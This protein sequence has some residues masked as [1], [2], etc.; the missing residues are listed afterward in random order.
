MSSIRFLLL[1]VR[2]IVECVYPDEYAKREGAT[3]GYNMVA[4][5]VYPVEVIGG[6]NFLNA[7]EDDTGSEK[8]FNNYVEI[9]KLEPALSA[10]LNPE[11][12]VPK[13]MEN[14]LDELRDSVAHVIN[15]GQEKFNVAMTLLDANE[16][17]RQQ[18]AEADEILA[19]ELAPAKFKVHM[20]PESKY[21]Q[22]KEELK[23]TKEKI[24]QLNRENNNLAVKLRQVTAERDHLK[25][26]ENL[27]LAVIKAGLKP[28]GNDPEKVV[29]YLVSDGSELDPDRD[30][31]QG[32]YALPF[33][34]EKNRKRFSPRVY[35]LETKIV[36]NADASSK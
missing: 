29:D 20:V 24:A 21:K 23:E 33:H 27:R 35:I 11:K 13:R 2:A 7:A 30:Q 16:K 3:Q 26:E 6:F 10:R 28:L 34:V 4:S 1:Q 12:P 31:K 17:I 8:R 22:L 14:Y 18:E 32:V 19:K 36:T 25:R 9:L 15:I 5:S